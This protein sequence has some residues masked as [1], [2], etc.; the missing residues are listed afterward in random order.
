MGDIEK[1]K[2]VSCGKVKAV[3]RKYYRYPINCKCCNG[4]HFEIVRHC[5][6]CKPKA[7]IHVQ[8]IVEPLK[9]L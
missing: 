3:Q 4:N 5:N 7:P 8:A 6:D 1:D 9:D 2:C